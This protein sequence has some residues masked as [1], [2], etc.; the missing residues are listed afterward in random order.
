MGQIESKNIKTNPKVLEEYP[1]L[2]NETTVCS[3]NVQNDL[4]TFTVS[5]LNINSLRKHSIDLKHDSRLFNSD[6]LAFTE[7]QLLTADHHSDIV[8]NLCHF[9]LYRQ[10]HSSDKFSSMAVCT[11]ETVELRECEFFTS[12]NAL[13]FELVHIETEETWTVLFVDAY[14]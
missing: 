2:Q 4:E 6:V 5:L 3:R 12:L 10:D 13:K 14:R 1:R 9:K 7:T 8:N 11:R